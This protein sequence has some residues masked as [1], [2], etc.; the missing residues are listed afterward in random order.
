MGDVVAGL[1]GGRGDRR[2][3]G[4]ALKEHVLVQAT[5]EARLNL[6]VKKAN[7]IVP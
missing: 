2:N 5:W 1:V 3:R 7:L 6:V 4:G